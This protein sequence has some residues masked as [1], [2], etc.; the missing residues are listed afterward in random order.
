MELNTFNAL[1]RIT[2][3]NHAIKFWIPPEDERV[4]AI[5]EVDGYCKKILL[6]F[7]SKNSETLSYNSD[8][9]V[10]FVID[11]SVSITEKKLYGLVR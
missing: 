5:I 6:L 10:P 3:S 2:R 9:Y 4:G 7:R 8:L 1:H 11:N